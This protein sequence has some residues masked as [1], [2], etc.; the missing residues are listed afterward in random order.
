[1]PKALPTDHLG[2]LRYVDV[3]A[4]ARGLRADDRLM[5]PLRFHYG[6]AITLCMTCWTVGASPVVM[7]K[8]SVSRFWEV[9]RRRDATSLFSIGSIPNLLLA[10]PPSPGDRDHA[11]RFAKAIGVPKGQH[12]DLNERFGFP[13]YEVYGSS[14]SGPALAMPSAF[15]EEFVGTG[16]VG[17]PY[18]DV[19]ARLVDLEGRVIEGAGEGELEL[20]GEILFRGYL[21]NPEATEAVL[22]DGWYRTG[23]LMRRD[24]RGMYYFQGRRKELIR[25]G[26]ENIA[27][28]EIEAVL[29]LHCEVIDAAVV[30]VEDDIWGEEIL[31]YVQAAEAR[32]GLP[33]ELASFCARRLAPFKV[34]RYI[35][36]RTE[37]FPRTPS[38]RIRKDQL[39]VNGT[40]SIV[41]AW[42]RDA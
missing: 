40:H 34:P 14:E 42:A 23:D 6:D 26:G 21:N 38:E 37:S 2:L 27:P 25:R 20:S 5:I 31:A 30:P 24:D 17:I 22:R 9:A 10:A 8:F 16:A 36:V 29:R 4:R 1:L 18:P 41:G 33:Q 13:W 15:A 32:P 39:K 7:R 3:G 12:R 35:T 28:S 11:I 19:D